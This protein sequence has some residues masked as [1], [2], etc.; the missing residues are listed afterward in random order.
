MTTVVVATGEE[1]AT[2]AE[3][4]ADTGAEVAV[5]A[6]VASEV[7]MERAISVTMARQVEMN[8]SNFSSLFMMNCVHETKASARDKVYTCCGETEEDFPTYCKYLLWR[9]RQ[10]VSSMIPIRIF[11]AIST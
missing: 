9:L 11:N 7:D 6:E 10:Q 1:V 8:P 2:E 5:E 3:A 4:E